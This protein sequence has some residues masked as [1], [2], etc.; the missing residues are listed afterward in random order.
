MIRYNASDVIKK[1]KQLADLENSDFISWNESITL[2][3]DAYQNIYQKSIN[4]GNNDFV[5]VIQ[6][7]EKCINLPRD[8]YQLKALTIKQDRLYSPILRRPQNC[9]FD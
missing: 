3:N 1:A 2:L 6:T 4:K 5:R 9:S 7:S 8:F